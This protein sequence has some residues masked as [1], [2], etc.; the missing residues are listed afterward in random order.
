MIPN[1]LRESL[2]R[3]AEHGIPTG[4][5]L[6]A[7]LENDFMQA[8]CRCDRGNVQHLQAIAK[9]I[10]NDMPAACHGSPE[11]VRAWLARLEFAGPHAPA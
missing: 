8:A 4:S 10:Y 9:Y 5:F 2:D 7:C 1:E 6:R 3:Y 11:A